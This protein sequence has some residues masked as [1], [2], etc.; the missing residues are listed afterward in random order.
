MRR[1]YTSV[2]WISQRCLH[3]GDS[4]AK[5][6]DGTN[7]RVMR[8]Q[9]GTWQAYLRGEAVHTPQATWDAG[10]DALELALAGEGILL[11]TGLDP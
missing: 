3:L 9:D 8:L 2:A 4:E 11:R 7:A 5:L 10:R 1:S 6:P